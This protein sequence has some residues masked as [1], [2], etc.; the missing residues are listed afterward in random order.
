[1][2]T[3]IAGVDIKQRMLIG[4]LMATTGLPPENM[5]SIQRT[6]KANNFGRDIPTGLFAG[7][8]KFTTGS[9]IGRL[10][11]ITSIR[12]IRIFGIPQPRDF[13]G[14]CGVLHFNYK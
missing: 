9:N 2:A 11:I 8:K 10:V 4:S 5:L 7:T 13:Y 12:V 3:T 14:T 1:M 6:P